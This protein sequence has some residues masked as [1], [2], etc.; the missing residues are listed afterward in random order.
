MLGI[1]QAEWR[2]GT[3]FAVF[4]VGISPASNS[5]GLRDRLGNCR[6]EE[7]TEK[8]KWLGGLPDAPTSS[9]IVARLLQVTQAPSKAAEVPVETPTDWFAARFSAGYYSGYAISYSRARQ[10]VSVGHFRRDS[11]APSNVRF[12]C[13]TQALVN[14]SRGPN[15]ICRTGK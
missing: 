5:C 12:R 1:G 11:V 13:S 3:D 8:A 2:A 14:N 7:Y 6:L 15:F 10:E 9:E 4:L